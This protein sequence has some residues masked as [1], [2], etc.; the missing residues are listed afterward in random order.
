[1]SIIPVL[2]N[3]EDNNEGIVFEN[4]SF[5]EA[6]VKAGATGR[7]VFIDCH[8]K[9]CVPCRF[10]EKNIFPQKECGDYMNPRYVCIMRDMEE[11]EGIELTKKF[12]VGIYPTFLVVNSDGSLYFMEIGSTK[13]ADK[14]VEKMKSA[15]ILAE[16]NESYDKGDRSDEFM[17]GYMALL[18]QKSPKKLLDIIVEVYM[19]QGVEKMSTPEIWTLIKSIAN[20]AD[21]PI[22]HYLVA[23]RDGFIARLGR[24]EVEQKIMSVYKEELRVLKMMPLDFDVRIADL[25]QLEKDGYADAA[26]L[27]Y[28]MFFRKIINHNMTGSVDELIAALTKIDSDI[29][30]ETMRATA[31]DNLTGIERV[32]TKEQKARLCNS[33]SGLKAGMNEANG[34]I[35]NR[36][37]L[38]LTK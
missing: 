5:K 2:C 19:P 23:Q 31:L 18:R 20:S 28:G 14:F 13:T 37:I 21:H 11:G 10:M 6:L 9:T 27:R 24:Q 7:K 12:N 35:V 4:I 33:L 8:T 26:M 30:D 22:F 17:S 32:A 34:N 16:M 38:R 36:I 1:M 15:A 25:V 29:P 3:A